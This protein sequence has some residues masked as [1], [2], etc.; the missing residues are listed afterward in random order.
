LE[1]TMRTWVQQIITTNIPL[2]DHLLRE[3]GIEF[4][5]TLDSEVAGLKKDLKLYYTIIN[6]PLAT[7]DIMN[8]DEILVMVYETFNLEQVITNSEEDNVPPTP[9]VNLS[10]AINTL[11]ILIRFQEQRENDNEFKSEELDMLYKK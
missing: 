4:A 3:K 2:S 1:L 8:D 10:K 7:E 9:L 6:E 5:H 11:N